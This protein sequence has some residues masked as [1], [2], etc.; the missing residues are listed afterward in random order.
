MPMLDAPPAPRKR[1]IARCGRK[2]KL[3]TTSNPWKNSVRKFPTIGN[4]NISGKTKF[5]AVIGHPV[6]HSLS[7]AMHNANFAANGDDAVY[8]ALNIPP[9]RVAEI[10]P[11]LHAAGC[12]GLSVTIPHKEILFR[13]LHQLDTSAQFAGAVNTVEF[14]LTGPKG[15]N[16]DGVGLLRAIV[17]S[18]GIG[19]ARKKVFVL[20]CGGA[21]RAVA[22]ACARAGAAQI[23]LANRDRKRAE[24]LA[25]EI[26][27]VS[28]AASS[29]TMNGEQP[30]DDDGSNIAVIAD[31][32]VSAC[33]ECEIV[34][35]CTSVGMKPG[36]ESLLPPEAFHAGQAA[37]DLIYT[38]PETPFMRAAR[39]AGAHAENGLGML[40]HQGAKQYEIWTGKKA[41]LAAMRDALEGAVYGR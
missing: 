9:E 22:L 31:D 10:V 3:A 12:G 33:R 11:A 41:N 15:H 39:A 26:S 7:P 24:R 38:S 5:F 16:T 32:S 21:G 23:V 36:E 19:V 35:Q 6:A 8:I 4:M 27:M 29:A 34:L 30:L 13:S 20:G 1:E 18:F 28:G 14:K 40:L 25:V 17:E 37:M 2:N